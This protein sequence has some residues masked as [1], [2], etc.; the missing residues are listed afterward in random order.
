MT[1]KDGVKNSSLAEMIEKTP[2]NRTDA[3]EFNLPKPVSVVEKELIYNNE[4]SLSA[5]IMEFINLLMPTDD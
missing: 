1:I 3:L 5:D 2:L 4:L